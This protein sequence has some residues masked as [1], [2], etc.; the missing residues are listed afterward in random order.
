MSLIKC[1]I[2]ELVID[3]DAEPECW[4]KSVHPDKWTIP[5]KPGTY[6]DIALCSDCRERRDASQQ[7]AEGAVEAHTRGLGPDEDI[8]GPSVEI[9]RKRFKRGML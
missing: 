8:D 6:P 2:C 1:A 5:G 4:R 9:A 3:T 7:R